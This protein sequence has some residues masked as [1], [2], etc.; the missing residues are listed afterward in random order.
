[1]TCILT[2]NASFVPDAAIL[3]IIWWPIPRGTSDSRY[4]ICPSDDIPTSRVIILP[5]LHFSKA[6]Q[7]REARQPDHDITMKLDYR[8][9]LPTRPDKSFHRALWDTGK[10]APDNNQRAIPH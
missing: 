4:N 10:A 9:T 6:P 8:G 1:M 2:F 3:F 7:L 5:S